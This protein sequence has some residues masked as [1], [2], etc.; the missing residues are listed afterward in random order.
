MVDALFNFT[1]KLFNTNPP[2]LC[3]IIT[4]GWC[5]SY[6]HKTYSFAL[7]IFQG[8]FYWLPPSTLVK[9][10]FMCDWNVSWH[11][12]PLTLCK[13][14]IPHSCT[15]ALLMAFSVFRKSKPF[16]LSKPSLKA[17]ISHNIAYPHKY[18]WF[19][20]TCTKPYYPMFTFQ[21]HCHTI[22]NCLIQY[23]W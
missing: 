4:I 20:S 13:K 7:L 12:T 10:I 15:A 11:C 22:Y 19:H 5:H 3:P 6:L 17:S 1:T 9:S 18:R 21:K 8:V 16:P 14:T 2:K 23:H